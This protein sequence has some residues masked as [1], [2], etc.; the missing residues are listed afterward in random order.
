VD[1]FNFYRDVKR[2]LIINE[3]IILEPFTENIEHNTIVLKTVVNALYLNVDNLG[4]VF[5]LF[6]LTNEC[7]KSYQMVPII[8]MIYKS[9]S[10]I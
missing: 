3:L 8:F 10:L 5:N 4:I 9:I 7:R 1:S 2:L 6:L